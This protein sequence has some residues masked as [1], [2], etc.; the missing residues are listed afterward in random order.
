MKIHGIDHFN[1]RTGDLDRLIGFYTNVLG[2]EVG[3]RPPFDSPG[4]W[5]YAGGHPLLH[6][7]IGEESENPSTLPFDHLA[8]SVSGLDETISRLEAH[9]VEFRLFDVPGRAMKQVFVR[10]PDGISLELNF[11]DPADVGGDA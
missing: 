1:I 3:E 6:V 5:L 2:F 9:G 11:T 8:F 7:G 4:A 10:D